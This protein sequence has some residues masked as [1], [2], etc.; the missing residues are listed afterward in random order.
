MK[1]IILLMI[2]LFVSISCS[3]TDD[4]SVQTDDNINEP[5]PPNRGYNMHLAL[6]IEFINDSGVN[7]FDLQNP[8]VSENDLDVDVY[9]VNGYENEFPYPVNYQYNTYMYFYLR[10]KVD[11]T[12]SYML[13]LNSY[14]YKTDEIQQAFGERGWLK[15][16][17]TFPDDVVYEVKV[18]GALIPNSTIDYYPNKIFVNDELKWQQPQGSNSGYMDITIVK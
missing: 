18:E 7:I 3:K 16:K 5:L 8:I 14:A 2:G 12:E 15:Y 9:G 17:I 4:H 6:G 10:T 13:V 1:K 11:N